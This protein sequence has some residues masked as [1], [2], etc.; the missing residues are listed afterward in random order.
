MKNAWRSCTFNKSL[1]I[2]RHSQLWT[3][4]G[5]AGRMYAEAQDS[6]V[7]GEWADPAGHRHWDNDSSLFLPDKVFSPTNQLLLFPTSRSPATA[8]N[9]VIKTAPYEDQTIK[10]DKHWR[11]QPLMIVTRHPTGVSRNKTFISVHEGI[12]KVT[13]MARKLW[14]EF[15]GSWC[16]GTV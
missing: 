15:R 8:G 12:N 3:G 14:T 13:W 7:Q 9:E 16:K 1:R 4:S 6:P 11:L 2:G 5:R 10:R